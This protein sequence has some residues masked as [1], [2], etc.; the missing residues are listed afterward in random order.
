M[1]GLFKVTLLGWMKFTQIQ[2]FWCSFRGWELIGYIEPYTH[3]MGTSSTL[4]SHS[5]EEGNFPKEKSLLWKE[6]QWKAKMQPFLTFE[7]LNFIK[8][9]P[10][11]SSIFWFFRSLLFL[12]P[13]GGWLTRE[14]SCLPT[15]IF[16]TDVPH[17]WS[18]IIMNSVL[19]HHHLQQSSN[20]HQVVRLDGHNSSE[21]DGTGRKWRTMSLHHGELP[22]EWW[23][24]VGGSS[25]EKSWAVLSIMIGK[26]SHRKT[27]LQ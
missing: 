27:F 19:C 12:W 17:S 26:R 18:F 9:S 11:I 25:W 8:Q 1:N 24:G 3:P 14:G 21:Q 4:I 6:G 23:F 20:N 2:S 22:G 10:G 15:M 16:S 5:S 7:N 13:S